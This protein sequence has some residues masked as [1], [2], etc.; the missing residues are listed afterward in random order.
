MFL[1]RRSEKIEALRNVAL[2]RALSARYLALIAREAD[3]VQVESGR[4]L[5]RQGGL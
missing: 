5:A 4:V 3:E 1:R 2:F